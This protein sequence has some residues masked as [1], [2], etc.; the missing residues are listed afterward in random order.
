M[1]RTRV[2]QRAVSVAAATTVVVAL[3]L[4]PWGLGGRTV[5]HAGTAQVQLGTEV[6]SATGNV[7]PTLP[8][9][10]TAGTLLVAVLSNSGTSSLAFSGP[11]GWVN[12]TGAWLSGP[13][14]AE[15]WYYANNP[16]GVSSAAFTSSAP[17]SVGQLSEWSGVAASSAL[18]VT[19]T[20]TA[21]SA[22]SVTVSTSASTSVTGDLGIVA[23]GTAVSETSYTAS[24]GWTH[25]FSDVTKHVGGDYQQ[26]L[27]MAIASD[28]E[29]AA[30]TSTSFV[31]VIATFKALL[32][33]GAVTGLSAVAGADQAT[34]SWTA[35]SSGGA[36]ASYVVT[37]LSG[38]TLARNAT[39]V[40][41]A[42]TS[43]VMTGLAGGTAYKFSVYGVNLGGSGPTATTASTV[44]VTG[45]AYPYTYSVYGDSPTLYYRFDER[46]GTTVLDSS[47]N[48]V[49]GAE[50]AS[51]TQGSAGLLSTDTDTG[52]AFNGST[53]Y[54]YSGTSVAGPSTFT[55]EAWFKTST[56]TGG[57]IIGFG[58]A[59]TGN[60]GSFDRQIYMSNTGQLYFG[61]YPGAVKTINSAASYNNGVAHHVVATLSSAG[62][63]LYVDGAQVASDPTT[64]TAQSYNGYWRVGDDNLSGWTSAPTSN[65]FNGTIDDVAVYPTALSLQRVQVHYCGGANSGCLSIA[66]PTSVAFPGQT[67]DGL[68]HTVTAT[69]AFDVVDNTGGNGWNDTAT[70]T[71]FVSGGHTLAA[72]A[73]SVMSAPTVSCDGGYTCTL[74][75][76]SVSYPYTL[77]TGTATKIFNAAAASGQG[78]ETATVTFTLSLPANAYAGS[79]A[80]TWTFSVVSGP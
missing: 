45:G 43:V 35:P 29:T 77:P 73:T 22:T 30:S 23:F 25:L 12:A 37:A 79:Y 65:F 47:G 8:A 67:L 1:C 72:N 38:G 64:T 24:S 56:A 59:Q 70:G 21:S 5:V 14:R 71:A 68:N 63:F 62:M 17:S 18:D 41:G 40:A 57:K 61:V 76:N 74:P 78:H 49:P 26:A 7:T 53:Q 39:A 42:T 32:A 36:V 10:S 15:I 19:G 44:T 50:V 33:P 11:S 9:A 48:G 28:T 31:A 80:S 2:A 51:P 16:G 75:T 58:S 34:V 4:S 55:L 20:K 66:Q 46:A 54:A 69:G 60:S 52:V 6:T 3:G 27:P 13:G